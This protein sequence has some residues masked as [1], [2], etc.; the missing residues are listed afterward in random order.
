MASGHVGIGGHALTPPPPEHAPPEEQA[1]QIPGQQGLAGAV[2]RPSPD[3]VCLSH[4][5]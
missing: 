5:I 3:L 1:D 4:G 2:A